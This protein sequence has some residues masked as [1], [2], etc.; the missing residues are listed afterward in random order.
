MSMPHGRFWR[1][2]ETAAKA[3]PWHSVMNE[4]SFLAPGMARGREHAEWS[5]PEAQETVPGFKSLLCNLRS[6]TIP[7]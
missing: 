6:I 7:F 4:W 1:E 3:L 2:A 5:R